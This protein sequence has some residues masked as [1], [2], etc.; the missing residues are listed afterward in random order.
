MDHTHTPSRLQLSPGNF[1]YVEPQPPEH[2][3]GSRSWR[4]GS[5][6]NFGALSLSGN[7]DGQKQHKNFFF[8]SE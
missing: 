2:I 7:D 1:S 4:S 3:A 5:V 8:D 6:L